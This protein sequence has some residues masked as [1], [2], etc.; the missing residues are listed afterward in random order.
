MIRKHYRALVKEGCDAKALACANIA[1]IKTAIDEKRI[2][3]AGMYQ[4]ERMLFLYLEIL[5][6]SLTPAKLFP[7]LDEALVPWV[8]MQSM[9]TWKEMNHIFYHTVPKSEEDWIREP[10]K[11]HFGRIAYLF[12]DKIHSY[13][14]HHKAIVD[15]GYLTGDKYQS[16]ALHEN[17]LFSVYEEPMIRTN[18]A[19]DLT[20]KS[21]AI[22]GWK[23]VDPESHF[24]HE[25]S[26]DMNFLIIP[27]LLYMTR[28][29]N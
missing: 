20:K 6:E 8:D 14:Y 16:I 10:D 7:T 22:E 21:V 24:D 4:H 27:E 5:D 25:L 23:A 17:V 13:V 26:G 1:N 12:P 28:S 11:K 29:K 9:V 15:E 3:T 2:L 19:G 18:I